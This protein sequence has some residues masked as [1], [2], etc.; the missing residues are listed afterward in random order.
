MSVRDWLEVKLS[1]GQKKWLGGVAR[2]LRKS[3][4]DLVP[5]CDLPEKI[6]IGTHHKTGS[7]W[8]SSIFKS[9][10]HYHSLVYYEDRQAGLPR[11]F[12]IFMNE[13]S[14]FEFDSLPSPYRGI[15][16]I[17]DPRDVIV[18]GCFYH[19]KS[20]EEWL[21]Q[22]MDDMDGRT[23][24]QKINSHASL[25]DQILFEMEHVGAR[26]IKAMMEWD[27][28]R[29]SFFE[30]K[31]EELIADLDLQLF[32][33]VFLFLG[34]PGSAI[35]SLLAIA[36]NNSLFSGRVRESLHVRSG[37]QQQW[38]KYF[39]QKH[40]QRFLELFGDALIVLGYEDDDNWNIVRGAREA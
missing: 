22:P 8:F 11:Q 33:K 35:P 37:D 32:Y 6:L 18:S 30:L 16:V 4:P 23:Y 34:F 27:Y 26:T 15:H 12:D 2:H 38:K 39:T 20:G 29:P 17:R 36:Y 21:H 9:V 19:Q 7:A 1:S 24:Q 5:G 3:Q 10:C 28:S 31:Y 14:E 25:D 40:K 13:H